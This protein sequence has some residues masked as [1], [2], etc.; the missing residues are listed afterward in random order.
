[1][2]KDTALEL[3]TEVVFELCF[4]WIREERLL[5]DKLLNELD[6]GMVMVLES[7]KKLCRKNL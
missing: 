1:V 2:G 6:M 3:W 7:V 4:F 5:V